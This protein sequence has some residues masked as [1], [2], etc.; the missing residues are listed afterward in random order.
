MGGFNITKQLKVYEILLCNVLF[1]FCIIIV[2]LNKCC[3]TKLVSFSL[4]STKKEALKKLWKINLPK[5]LFSFV[6]YFLKF[7]PSEAYP[8]HSRTS[9][10]EL[11]GKIV[12][13]WKY[14]MAKWLKK[15]KFLIFINSLKYTQC[16]QETQ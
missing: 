5:E 7:L 12:N 10:M 15:G 14:L 13:G 2:L 9:K 6:R 3:N 16:I 4:Y 1:C 8:E 11:F